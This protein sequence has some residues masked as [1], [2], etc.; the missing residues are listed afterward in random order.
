MT[1]LKKKEAVKYSLNNKGYF[2]IDNYN[3]AKSF[4]SFFSGVAGLWG[5]PMWVFYVNRG[6]CIASFGIHSKDKSIMEFQ[7]ANKS[8]RLATLQGFRTFIKIKQGQKEIFWE[9]FQNNLIGT[10]FQKKQTMSISAHDLILEEVNVDLGLSIRV[11]YFTLPD[12][13]FS[14]LVRQITIHNNGV[15]NYEVE[16]IDGMPAIVPYGLKDWLIK[17]LARTAEAW[18]KVRNVEKNAPFYQLNVEVADTPQVTHIHEGNFFF[19]FDASAHSKS[20]LP[21]IV[22]SSKLFGACLDFSAPD[23]FISGR[24]K[25]GKPQMTSNKTPCAFSYHS[26]KL[27]KEKT[28]EIISVFGYA[29]DVDQLNRLTVHVREPGFVASKGR[30]NKEIIDHI[31]EYVQMKSSSQNFD[32]YTSHTFLDNILR[33]GLPISVKTKEGNVT[34]NVYS[35]KHGDLER[36]YN[37]FTVAPT[38]FSQGNG[39]FRDVNQNRRNDVWFNPEVKDSHIISFFNLSQADGYNPLVVKGASFTVTDEQEMKKILGA[40][41]RNGEV[42]KLEEFLLK[43][44]QPGELLYFIEQNQYDVQGNI[45]DLL[46]RI[47]EISQKQELADHGEGFWTDHWTYNLD[48]VESYLSLYPEA[49]KSL[50]FNNNEYHFYLNHHYV[51][52]RDQRFF[53]TKYGVRQYESVCDDSE[54]F[55]PS[56][57]DFKLKTKQGQGVVYKTSLACKILCLIANK[58]ASLDPSGIGIEMEADK[59]GWYDALNGLPGLVGSSICESLELHRYAAFLLD[60]LDQL[61]VDNTH[62]IPVFEELATFITGLTNL[63]TSKQSAIDYWN[64]SNDIKENYRKRVRRAIDGKETAMTFL[65]IKNF[66]VQVKVKTADSLKNARNEKGQLVTYFYHEVTDYK[67]LDSQ[68]HKDHYPVRPL[69]FKKHLLPLFLEGYVHAL[70]IQ[71]N[72]ADAKRLFNQ[73]IESDLY[74]QEL[75]MFKVNASLKTETEEIGRTR[76]F[77]S[78]WL[79]NES[80]WLH[81]EYKFLLELLRA[82]LYPE[83][84]K[85]FQDVLIP[86]LKPVQYGRSI[87][88]NSS[89]IVSSAH[90]DQDLHGQGFVA[91][92]SGST[93]EFLHIWLLMNA[94]PKP[95]S[96]NAKNELALRLNPALSGTLFTSKESKIEFVDGQQQRHKWTLP[97]NIYA[98]KFLNATLV[99]YHNPKRID[100]FGKKNSP[101]KK[102]EII[103]IGQDQPVTLMSPV[104]SGTHASLIREGKASRMD[105]HLS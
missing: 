85:S 73:V 54:E 3:Q 30:Q 83:F 101:I 99:V 80:I 97:K 48:L 39:N 43:S 63:L 28:Q 96:V 92:L 56:V 17:N 22:E 77:P 19:S 45:R 20:L 32:L 5:I 23:E 91:R 27:P 34:F 1:K 7:P 35:R 12:E 87:L 104:I 66:L 102:I 53:L 90:E 81:M 57:Y 33:G 15:K 50:L 100:T 68:N 18:V 55:D 95:F 41:I 10:N 49:L 44:F 25:P 26:F 76:V 94:G 84:F 74:D 86:Y 89:F 105:V 9:P 82:K 67:K 2:V 24:F 14:G 38:Y 62:T 103:F 21:T 70:K 72:T 16:V 71:E 59:P 52:P 47:L 60:S 31:K 11:T 46:G 36:D 42:K 78:G 8:Y 13:P 37:H 79:E 4:C 6:Q 65:E 64:K 88:E 75:K 61:K 69:G 51:R 98:F 29:R 93:A 58:V 40:Y